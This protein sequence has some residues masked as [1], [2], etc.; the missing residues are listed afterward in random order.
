M[1]LNTEEKFVV[2]AL[3]GIALGGTCAL[4]ANLGYKIGDTLW[5]ILLNV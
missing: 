4:F 3:L 5:T 2:S 1:K